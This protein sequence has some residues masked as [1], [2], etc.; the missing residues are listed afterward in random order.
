MSKT[1]E[2]T[3]LDSSTLVTATGG[4]SMSDIARKSQIG[5]PVGDQPPRP[6]LED[7]GKIDEGQ[8]YRERGQLL[9]LRSPK[10]AT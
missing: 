1:I 4:V 3:T 7:A 2:L 10:F 5:S 9:G 8:P 6:T